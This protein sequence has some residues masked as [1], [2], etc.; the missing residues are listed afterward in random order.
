MLVSGSVRCPAYSNEVVSIEAELLATFQERS[1][2]PFV[3]EIARPEIAEEQKL[4]HEKFHLPFAAP[5]FKWDSLL[6]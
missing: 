4:G 1:E 3:A 2:R 6:A 5:P